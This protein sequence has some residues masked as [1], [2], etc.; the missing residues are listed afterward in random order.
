MSHCQRPFPKYERKV[1][2][3]C[4]GDRLRI[5]QFSSSLPAVLICD[6][7]YCALARQAIR[8]GQYA[9]GIAYSQ[10]A[11]ALLEETPERFWLAH[12]FFNL[13]SSYAH[14]G[15]LASAQHSF[16]Q[17]RQLGEAM[18][19]R[20]VQSYAAWNMGRVLINKRE[21]EAAITMGRHALALATTNPFNVALVLYTLG[22][23]YLEQG[24]AA[25]AISTLAQALDLFRQMQDQ[26]MQGM[27]MAR[28]GEAYLVR[29]DVGQAY[30]LAHQG[31][32]VAIASHVQMAMRAAQRVLGRI[33]LARGALAEAETH[34]Q[35]ALRL[36]DST[37]EQYG[38]GI[39][40]L[41]LARLAHAQGNPEAVTT[42][43]REARTL[44]SAL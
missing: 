21:Y 39:T 38:L 30:D 13:G 31:L 41:D 23:A 14:L 35:E 9:Q 10:Q 1:R 3:S 7:V 2:R 19:D 18:G 5:A 36:C 16:T 28:L 40:H 22:W 34:L 27:V 42:H 32:A 8:A 43:L 15:E 44:F 12:S 29:G 33:A 24:E 25:Q 6:N 37:Q 4:D 17:M 20:R 26:T 11:I